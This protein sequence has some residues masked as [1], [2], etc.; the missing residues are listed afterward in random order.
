MFLNDSLIPFCDL[1]FSIAVLCINFLYNDISV[2]AL[3][4]RGYELC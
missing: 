3:T 4:T 1:C 2:Y